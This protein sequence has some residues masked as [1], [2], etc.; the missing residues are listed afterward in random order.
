MRHTVRC[1][2][3]LL[4]G[5]PWSRAFISGGLVLAL[6]AASQANGK[7]GVRQG[8]KDAEPAP[9]GMEIVQVAGYPE[10]RVEGKPFFVHSAAFFYYRM[11][12]D[13]WDSTLDEYRSLGINTVDIYIPWNWHETT[14]GEFDFD[15]HTNPRR[16]LRALLQLIARKKLKLIAR[17]GPT[18]LNEWRNGGYP[19]WLL[20]RPEYKMP[21]ADILEGR[22]P[23][24]SNLNARDSE[25]AAQGW[26]SNPVHMEY[27]EKWMTAVA[28][29]LAMYS[30]HRFITIPGS[31]D[32]SS[33]PEK[34]SGP[35]LFVQLED[36]MAIGRTNTIGADFWKY[37]RTLRG[38]LKSGGLDAVFFINP[39]DMR[40]T[41]AGSGL[42]EPIGAMGQWYMPPRGP[43]VRQIGEND[44]STVELYAD[45]LKTQPDFPAAMI[46]F[47]AGW[48]CPGDDDRP[49]E[50]PP[51][52]TLLASRL[53]IGDGVH[54]INY[55][56][57][58]DT[59]T[60]AGYSVPWT[61]RFYRWD[62]ALGV[63]GSVQPRARAVVRN[64]DL[65]ARWG[66]ELASSHKRVDFAIVDPLG[67]F[68]QAALSKEEIEKVRSAEQRLETLAQIAHLSAE[69]AD[70][71]FQPADQLLRYPILMLPVF[72]QSRQEFQMS[73]KAQTTIMD[74]VRR[75]GTLVVFPGRPTGKIIDDLWK[76]VPVQASPSDDVIQASWQFGTGQVIESL[77][78]FLTAR[79][80]EPWETSL[81]RP[82]TAY[83][84]H[85]I[86]ELF[87][88]TRVRAGVKITGNLG[89][90]ADLVASE[91]VSD[92]GSEPLGS[93]SAGRGFLSVTNLGDTDIGPVGIQALSPEASARGER[94]EYLVTKI[95]VPAHDSLLLPLLEP[96]C[97]VS[98]EPPCSDVAT[99]MGA[100]F[101]DSRID[102][103]DLV[104]SLYTPARADVRLKLEREP[105][106]VQM[107]ELKQQISYD[108][109]SHVLSL[110]IPRGPS[111]TYNR[112]LRLGMHEKEAEK[113]PHKNP[114]GAFTISIPNGVR[115][116][117]G[118]D[119]FVK[120]N[121]PLIV[122]EKKNATELVVEA[123]SNG[124]QKAREADVQVTGPFN[125]SGGLRLEPKSTS[126]ERIKLRASG[127][128]TAPDEDGLIEGTI[129]VHSGQDRFQ[130][131]IDYLIE[132]KDDETN[133]R[134]DFD[135]DGAKEW[136]M[137]SK[138]LRLIVSPESGGRAI[139]LVAKNSGLNLISSVGG[140]R[141]GFSFAENS[142]TGNPE[143]ARGR[144]G[145][146]NRPY[147]AQW[148]TS[149]SKTALQME[150]HAPDVFPNGAAIEKTMRFE[151]ADTIRVEY[152]IN[153]RPPPAGQTV[154]TPQSFVTN[155][156][157]PAISIG[158]RTTRFCWG[159]PNEERH[160]D[161]N[162]KANVAQ[163]CKDFVAGG[164]PIQSPSGTSRVEVHTPGEPSMAIEWQGGT[165]T[166]EPKNF[167]ALLRLQFPPLAR[168][169]DANYTVSVRLLGVE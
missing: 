121:P 21:V 4:Q 105:S 69:L 82:E 120:S 85:A 62:A 75:G 97:P 30:S 133:Y 109:A 66:P 59:I 168:G 92:E 77:K 79:V 150:Y 147:R 149:D 33:K 71:E 91:L 52:N 167:S 138:N 165:M 108:D 141:D 43:G 60:P 31:G 40:V 16:N 1:V 47:Q 117:L 146:F 94:G 148:T 14:E 7:A 96:I 36:D 46:E 163:S 136:V 56:P 160:S 157:V 68:S 35:L 161:T 45:E 99:I 81:S 6:F 19:D 15:G 166:I 67:S 2:K 110:E 72:D 51:Y 95:V 34:I 37:M 54:G 53:L 50:S 135:R 17:P 155:T 127:D 29:E 156:S 78:D 169:A 106:E 39:T 142:S 23:P 130:S 122:M 119:A 151:D 164:P 140:M 18:I 8:D 132:S 5:N 70:P 93:R 58:Q 28:R 10:L 131:S 48:Y 80:E 128:K 26:L 41:A 9:R 103:K 89:E 100:E 129:D 104:L 124:T 139:A 73:A 111:P 118:R 137:E 12:R 126:V 76:E 101:L 64:R 115:L 57:L 44:A 42:D 143:R 13:L 107:D 125:G 63:D 86:L 55:F 158:D 27:A 113:N 32:P 22:Y 134:Y 162:E 65:L 154:S 49:H 87:A 102:D 61:N 84:L 88:K 159:V 83:A 74:Y 116:P 11:P 123:D 20:S 38:W 24:L 153:L 112:T 144:Y 25:A 145:L 114:S 98:Q 90:L 152:K 3:S